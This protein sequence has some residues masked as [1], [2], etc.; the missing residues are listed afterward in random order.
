MEV[1]NGFVWLNI[2]TPPIGSTYIQRRRRQR[3]GCWGA[4]RNRAVKR[5]PRPHALCQWNGSWSRGAQ[6]FCS[7]NSRP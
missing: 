1:F 4:N 5:L 7:R 6:Y 2:N 3:F